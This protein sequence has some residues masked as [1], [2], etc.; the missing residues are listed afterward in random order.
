MLQLRRVSK[1]SLAKVLSIRAVV[2]VQAG[3]SRSE[4]GPPARTRR[5]R[6]RKA[7]GSTR[8]MTVRFP[9][10]RPFLLPREGGAALAPRV[11]RV[12]VL[13]EAGGA[14]EGRRVI[15]ALIRER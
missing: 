11:I 14:L 12:L 13:A 2:R 6:M 4:R 3:G 8:W 5:E 7:L 10:L 15:F 9:I 1:R